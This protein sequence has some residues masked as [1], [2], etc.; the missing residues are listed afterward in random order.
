MALYDRNKTRS[1]FSELAHEQDVCYYC[2]KAIREKRANREIDLDEMNKQLKQLR[3]A[4]A[5]VRVPKL[6]YVGHEMTICPNCLKG[7]CEEVL[8]KEVT[9]SE[10]KTEEVT[11]DSKNEQKAKGKGNKNAT[12]KES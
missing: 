1:F 7:I 12:S 2:E 9:I 6:R 10:D 5:N 3:G 4:I 11:T 8:P